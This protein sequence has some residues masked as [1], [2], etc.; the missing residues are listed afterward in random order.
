FVLISSFHAN[1]VFDFL[2][3]RWGWNCF[4]NISAIGSLYFN[5]FK[6]SLYLKHAPAGGIFFK[7]DGTAVTTNAHPVLVHSQIKFIIGIDGFV[8][9]AK[10]ILRKI[11]ALV[12]P[13]NQEVPAAKNIGEFAFV[14]HIKT[15]RCEIIAKS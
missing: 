8:S 13:A 14:I 5:S 4:R 9:G 6:N 15:L 3:F 2:Q 1:K 11:G 10:I 12:M 7:A